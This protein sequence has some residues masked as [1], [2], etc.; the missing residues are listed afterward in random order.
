MR[1]FDVVPNGFFS[2]LTSRNRDIYVEMLLVIREDFKRSIHIERSSLLALLADR[3]SELEDS[4]CVHDQLADDDVDFSL[5]ES[6]QM[7]DSFASTTLH[8]LRTHETVQEQE[9]DKITSSG[10]A[11]VILRRLIAT[12]WLETEQRIGSFELLITIPQYSIEMMEWLYKITQEDNCAYKN[13][14]FGAYSSL[15]TLFE[16]ESREYWF[17]A[18]M[19]ARESSQQ[20]VD[21]LK[22]LLNNIRRYHRNL[23]DY[24]S[25]NLVLREHFDE[26]QQLVNERIFHPLVTRDAVQRFRQ[27]ILQMISEIQINEDKLDVL[28]SQGM[29]ESYYPTRDEAYEKVG[30]ILVSIFDVFDVVGDLMTDIQN[31]NNAYTKASVDKLVYL[32]NKDRSNKEHIAHI[33]MRYASIPQEG[34]EQLNDCVRLTSVKILDEKSLFERGKQKVRSTQ[35]PIKIVRAPK[36]KMEL[37]DFLDEYK[38]HYTYK[39]TMEYVRQLFADRD[40]ILSTDFPFESEEAFVFMLMSVVYASEKSA[41]YQ[42]EFLPESVETGAYHYPKIR[43]V[44]KRESK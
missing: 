26:Y 2:L 15:K 9:L 5:S 42:I 19:N 8:G 12:G 7:T 34:K 18:L 24:A 14:A 32:L 33:L 37:S 21:A 25:A 11:R 17:T 27:Q 23:G 16:E 28:C 13:Y 35:D 39:G 22:M 31:K 10:M 1:V 38:S 43:Y 3:I 30:E 40:S 36:S 4:S 20:L 6:Y 41:F 29:K 44:R